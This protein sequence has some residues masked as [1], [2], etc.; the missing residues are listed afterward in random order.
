MKKKKK[1][2]I[3]SKVKGHKP[4][5]DSQGHILPGECGNPNGRPKGSAN[6]YSLPD[7][8]HAIQ[9]VENQKGR[10][11]LLEHFIERAYVEDSVL[12]AL[13]KK[14]LPDLK[15][16]EGF[17]ATFESSMTDELAKSIQDKLRKKYGK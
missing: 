4:K 3:T 16:I 8:W 6:R 9:K 7:F 17:M 10:K 11:K 1:K 13:M 2:A 5:R 15:S 14:L 12:V